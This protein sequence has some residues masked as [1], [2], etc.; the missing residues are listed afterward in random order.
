MIEFLAGLH[1]VMQA[2]LATCFTWGVT[3]LGAASVFTFKEVS[4]RVLDGM[5]GF[6]AGVMIAASFWSLL[7]PSIE[8]AEATGLPAWFPAATGFLLGGVFLRGADRML[9]RL[10]CCIF[11]GKE[12]AVN[13]DWHRVTPLILAIT[14]HKIP[15]GLSIGVAF[16][17]LA[18]GYPYATLVGAITLAIEIQNFPEGVAVSMP[19]P[20]ARGCLA[21]GASVW[22][23]VGGRRADR[24]RYRGGGSDPRESPSSPTPWGLPRGD[25]F[26]GGRG[27]DPRVSAGRERE[28][29]HGRGDDRLYCDDGAGCGVW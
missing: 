26:R 12:G 22:S 14:L 29:G 19:T 23:A 16:G 8:M 21:R 10:H 20:G 15:V 9:P 18:A 25:D 3:A 2:F 4:G 17:A 28:P 6:A 1:P 11:S 27:A 7:A 24:R 5:L 13:A